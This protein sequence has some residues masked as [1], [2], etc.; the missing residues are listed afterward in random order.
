MEEGKE[1]MEKAQCI[2]QFTCI[3]SAPL[4][5]AEHV[6]EAHAWD[7]DSAVDFY[8]ESGGV[9]HGNETVEEGH[10]DS[11]GAVVG[12][13]ADVRIINSNKREMQSNIVSNVI[14]MEDK[15]KNEGGGEEDEN[16]TTMDEIAPESNSNKLQENAPV[17]V[18]KKLDSLCIYLS[19]TSLLIGFSDLSLF[20]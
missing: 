3:T 12:R 17:K 5:V 20:H 9:G 16:L 11:H 2:R 7:L 19:C 15:E 18:R 8:L 14:D 4:H 1:V 13:F 10:I 6:L